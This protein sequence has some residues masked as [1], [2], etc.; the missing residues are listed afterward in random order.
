MDDGE[1]AVSLFFVLS[2]FI[3]AYVYAPR[4]VAGATGRRRFWWARFARVYPLY[5]LSVIV[6]APIGALAIVQGNPPGI[7]IAKT[8]AALVAN[9]GLI[10]AWHPRL[11]Y[12]CN[13]PAWSLSAEAFYYL[14]FPFL[15]ISVARFTK[16][17]GLAICV[18][19]VVYGCSICAPIAVAQIAPQGLNLSA[20]VKYNPLLRLPEFLIGV[21]AGQ[22]FTGIA[23]EKRFAC[24]RRAG[25]FA[26]VAAVAILLLECEPAHLP[27]G[28]PNRFSPL[29]AMLIYSLA[30]QTGPLNWLLSSRWLVLAG[31][32]SYATYLLHLPLWKYWCFASN[33]EEST[34]PTVKSTVTFILVLTGISYA[35]YVLVE[36]PARAWLRG[37]MKQLPKQSID[38]KS[39]TDR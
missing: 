17:I 6:A 20:V 1:T 19:A 7:G 30:F 37:S 13:L 15:A 34:S 25:R 32:A 18:I 24:A 36:R 29:Y 2:G 9:F 38:E 31:E 27:F 8:A 28:H 33:T 3:L 23:V 21:I 5:A 26:V 14:L 12:T 11:V 16:R 10:Q 35:A 22:L 4:S 39:L